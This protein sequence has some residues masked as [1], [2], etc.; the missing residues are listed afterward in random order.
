MYQAY[1]FWWI[2]SDDSE[3]IEEDELP[4]YDLRLVGINWADIAAIV[5]GDMG[6][7]IL[8]AY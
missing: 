7:Y 4:E 2:D 3:D 6:D 5:R 8:E 1:G